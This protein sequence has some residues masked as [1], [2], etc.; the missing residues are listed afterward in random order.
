MAQEKKALLEQSK[1]EERSLSK[2]IMIAILDPQTQTTHARYELMRL[3]VKTL[4]SL[5]VFPFASSR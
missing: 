1:K 5:T 4:Q 2:M 3:E